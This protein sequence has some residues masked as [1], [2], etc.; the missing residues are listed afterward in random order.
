MQEGRIEKLYQDI[1]IRVRDA[2]EI[3]GITQELLAT[4]LGLSRASIIN[5][6]KGRHRP[7]V[8]LLIEIAEILQLDYTSL[9][10]VE[11]PAPALRS[12]KPFD[13]NKVL[14]YE[15]ISSNTEATIKQIISSI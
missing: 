8:H 3:N 13:L 9:I 7:S 4:Q 5:L 11:N 14:S 6:E 1:G 15:Q 10:P 2:R 12:K